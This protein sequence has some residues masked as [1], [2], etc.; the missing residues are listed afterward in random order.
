MDKWIHGERGDCE[1]GEGVVG[2]GEGEAKYEDGRLGGMR[3]RKRGKE[4]EE[5]KGRK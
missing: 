2:G 5:W 3:Q 4:A 1:S